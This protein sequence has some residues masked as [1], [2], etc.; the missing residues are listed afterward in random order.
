MRRL[1]QRL[2]RGCGET[3]ANRHATAPLIGVKGAV[4][5]SGVAREVSTIQRCG[6][7]VASMAAWELKGGPCRRRG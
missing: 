1:R 4:N 2:W 6:R 5:A 3:E 7:G